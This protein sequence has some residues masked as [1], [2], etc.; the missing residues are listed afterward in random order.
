MF[1]LQLQLN[2]CFHDVVV[3]LCQAVV[4][5]I[6]VLVIFISLKKHQR[7]LVVWYS[8]NTFRFLKQTALCHMVCLKSYLFPA[9][10]GLF[11]NSVKLQFDFS[12][13]GN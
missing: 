12:I 10:Q 6:I 7:R 9:L 1:D 2:G 8:T 11:S 3:A 4:S 5:E 13:L